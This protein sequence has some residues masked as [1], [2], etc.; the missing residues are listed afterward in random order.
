MHPPMLP[1]SDQID[2]I[3]GKAAEPNDYGR[4]IAVEVIKELGMMQ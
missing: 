1:E 4:L 2:A 3:V